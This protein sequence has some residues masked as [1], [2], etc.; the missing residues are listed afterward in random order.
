LYARREYGGS[1][2]RT[3]AALLDTPPFSAVDDIWGKRYD[4]L[5]KPTALQTALP[6]AVSSACLSM[7]NWTIWAL[8]CIARS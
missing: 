4:F 2:A 7:P 3:I 1:S 8:P 6:H 5:T